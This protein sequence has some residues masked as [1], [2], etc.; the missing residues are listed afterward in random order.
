[1]IFD[2][3]EPRPGEEMTDFEKFVSNVVLASMR[4]TGSGQY[5][6]DMRSFLREAGF[7]EPEFEDLTDA[8]RPSLKRLERIAGK[9]FRHPALVKTMRAFISDDATMN[10]I[11]GW[12]IVLSVEKIHGYCRLVAEKPL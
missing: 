2:L 1:M 12:L 11:A 7:N 9:Y 6:G 4:V 3:F 10:G 5:I 8:I